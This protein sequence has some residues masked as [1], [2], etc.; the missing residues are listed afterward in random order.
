M[1]SRNVGQKGP[2]EIIWSSLN[3]PSMATVS[4]EAKRGRAT[5]LLQRYFSLEKWYNSTTS[6]RQPVKCF[7]SLLEQTFYVTLLEH[8]WTL[9]V[10]R[11]FFDVVKPAYAGKYS[12]LSYM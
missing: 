9:Y 5:I 4:C 8:T 11:T 3:I 6:S 10:A 2:P 1:D 7:I 12:Y